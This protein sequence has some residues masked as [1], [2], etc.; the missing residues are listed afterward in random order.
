[1][2]GPKTYTQAELDAAL[3]I[4]RAQGSA[5]MLLQSKPRRLRTV[6]PGAADRFQ[7]AIGTGVPL[8]LALDASRKPNG[9]CPPVFPNAGVGAWYA[10]QLLAILED[11]QASVLPFI[12]A[13]YG[14]TESL[15]DMAQDAR[16]P[17]TRAELLDE[18]LRKWGGLW[19][20]RL[21][22]MAARLATQ[23][24]DKAFTATETSMRDSFRRGG[25]T[26][27]FKPTAATLEATHAVT[28]DNVGLI[29]SIA[30]K[31]HDD[32][33][34]EVWASVRKGG[35]LQQLTEALKTKHGVAK[36]RA[37]FIALD[38][39]VKAKATIEQTRRL[40]LG[41][42]KAIWMHSHAGKVPRPDHVKANGVEFD[43]AQGRWDAD[44]KAYVLPGF[45]I[46]CRCTSRAVI[47]GFD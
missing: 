42:K 23:F 22:K 6:T 43:I 44:E 45:L 28:A 21:D 3:E 1:M 34:A 15:T 24:T 32:V 30:Q 4:A 8:V 40:E 39:N 11:M 47:P 19:I 16:K 20:K 25:L 36:K 2:T 13:A 12:R 35:D 5:L 38:Q 26:V 46:K 17:K 9:I 31:Y 18:G 29:K 10:A 14:R 41:I 27:K 7:R 33:R 37:E